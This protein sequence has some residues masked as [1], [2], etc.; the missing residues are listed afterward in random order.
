MQNNLCQKWLVI[1]ITVLF[2]GLISGSAV[3]A[4]SI[5]NKKIVDMSIGISLNSDSYID[6]TVEEAWNMLN[7]SSNGVQIPID[8]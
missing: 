1:G 6:I 4:L 5:K 3:S 7:D 2:L 8:V